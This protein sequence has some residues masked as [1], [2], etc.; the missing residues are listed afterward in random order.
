MT[1]MTLSIMVPHGAE[2]ISMTAAQVNISFRLI[3]VR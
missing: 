1:S 2:E 3:S